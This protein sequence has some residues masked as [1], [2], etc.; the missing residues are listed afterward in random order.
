MGKWACRSRT[1]DALRDALEAIDV[2]ME[3]ALQLRLLVLGIHGGRRCVAGLHADEGGDQVQAGL[4]PS[5]GDEQDLLARKLLL[6]I[7]V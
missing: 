3:L 2:G 1:R 6:A 4:A 7:G 5:P